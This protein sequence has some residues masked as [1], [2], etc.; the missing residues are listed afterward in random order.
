[1]ENEIDQVLSGELKGAMILLQAEMRCITSNLE[2]ATR[3]QIRSLV[4]EICDG[5]KTGAGPDF[6][7]RKV[8]E[9][10]KLLMSITNVPQ[11]EVRGSGD[12]ILK[13]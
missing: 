13:K 12:V 4:K 8:E 11:E 7:K 5:L 10:E 3:S 1:L 9:L 2:P 6:L